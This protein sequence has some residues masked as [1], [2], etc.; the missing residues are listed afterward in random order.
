MSVRRKVLAVA[1]ACHPE[2]GSEP[3]IGWLWARNI[4]AHHDVTVIAGDY[5]GN[6]EAIESRLAADGELARRLR[7]VFI[8]WIKEPSSRLGQLV[9][10]YYQPLFYREYARWM[11]QAQA[12]ATALIR[13]ERFDISHQIT[14]GCYREP[15]FLWTLP[16][17]FVWGPLG[18]TQNVPNQFLSSLGLA[19]GARHL[20]R[21]AINYG[22]F[23]YR[24]RVRLALDRAQAVF[25]VATNTQELLLRVHGKSS[26]VV[27]STFCDPHHRDARLRSSGAGPLRF[28]FSALHLSRKGLPFALRAL[29][30]L[31]SAADWHLDVLGDG[32]MRRRWK[33]EA[34]RLGLWNRVTFRGY[35]S[36]EDLREVMTRG[37]V[38]VLP[39]LQDSWPAVVADA[40]SLGMPVITTDLHG[41][42]DM[43]TDECGYRVD[44][45][46]PKSLVDGLE[47]A[48]RDLL[49]HPDRLA[50]L[51]R[52]ALAR[53]EALSADRQLSV[54][55]AAYERAIASSGA[56]QE[57]L[58]Q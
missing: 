43:I 18:G 16:M 1:A 47:S 15:G 24:R 6:R 52:G 5:D 29:A 51:S 17:P 48:F 25:S 34:D 37:D 54:V 38:F 14:L 30:R 10:H 11:A 49:F 28:V 42:H 57:Q 40:L 56:D 55:L 33:A 44:A 46:T 58:S 8:P 50:Q 4:A 26:D 2:R 27:A 35:L 32:R 12:A 23:R 53:A 7:F 22:Q 19:E 45:S 39:S 13:A 20:A 21:N 36:G 3:G 9:W 31:P 41:M